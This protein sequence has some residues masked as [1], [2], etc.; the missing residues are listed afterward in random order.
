MAR[1]R[2]SESE[3]RKVTWQMVVTVV[4]VVVVYLA[5]PDRYKPPY[6]WTEPVFDAV[7]WSS[8]LAII[9]KSLLRQ[10]RFWISLAFGIAAQ[11]WVTKAL[12]VSGMRI[13]PKIGGLMALAGA[14]VWAALYLVFTQ[15]NK[16]LGY[17]E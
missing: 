17:E 16:G 8:L 9:C 10:W 5:L 2:D 12:I 3:D 6:P 15:I 14:A 7:V 11:I 13:S 4:V 1:H